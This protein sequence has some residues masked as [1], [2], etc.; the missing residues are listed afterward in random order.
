MKREKTLGW[1]IGIIA[2]LAS[3]VVFLVPFAFIFVIAAK[4]APE[5]A[6]LDFTWPTQW[7]AV[8]QHP[9]RAD[10]PQLRCA[11]RVHQQHHA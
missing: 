1:V 8:G 2:V 9:G 5:A 4:T 3:I 10:H 11:A 7:H 6:N